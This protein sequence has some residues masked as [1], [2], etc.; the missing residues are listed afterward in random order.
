MI[1]LM[2]E[3]SQTF[4]KE[5]RKLGVSA[6]YLFG[7]RAQGRAGPLS[8]YD[9]GVLLK[10][11]IPAKKYLD[12]KLHLM[13]QFSAYLRNPSVEVVLLNEAPPL[14]AMNIID[15][16]RL[17]FETDFHFRVSF[18]TKI[19]MQYLDRLPYERRYLKT[20]LHSV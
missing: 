11:T 15:G 14:L 4:K 7:S 9:F 13:A 8:D 3:F 17:L 18:E 12:K 5:L 20:L 10:G 1:G 16:G 6:V 2:I 19:T